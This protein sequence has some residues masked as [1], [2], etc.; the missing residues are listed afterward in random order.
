M[1]KFDLLGYIRKFQILIIAVSILAGIMGYTVLSRMQT[2]T[3]SAII[4]YANSEAVRGKAPDGSQLDTTEIYSANVV[5]EVFSRMGLDYAGFNVDDMRARVEVQALRTNEKAAL[6][7]AL[8]SKGEEVVEKPVEY[9]VSFVAMNQ[10]A[11]NQEEFA[12]QFLDEMLDAYISDYG[13]NHINNASPAINDISKINSHNYDYLEKAELLKNSISSANNALNRKLESADEQFRSTAT[14]YSF[15]DLQ[16]EFAL[17]K[18]V[19]VPEL[20]AY[21]LENHVTQDR[22]VLIAKY[23]NRIHDHRLSNDK[24]QEQIAFVRGIIDAYVNMMRESGNTNITYEY[25]IQDV[26]DNW[27]ELEGTEGKYRADQTVEYDTLLEDY[28]T[29]CTDYEEALVDIAYCQYILDVYHGKG[30]DVDGAVVKTWLNID[31]A[32]AE[33]DAQE[34]NEQ[35]EN[36]QDAAGSTDTSESIDAAGTEEGDSELTESVSKE[37]S[38]EMQQKAQEMIDNLAE[39]A[40]TLHQILEITNSEYNEYIGAKNIKLVAGIAVK[41]RISIKKYVVLLVLVFGI[42]GCMGAIVLGRL[43][44]IFE[45]YVYIDRVLNIP[46][47]AACDR[48]INQYGKRSLPDDFVCVSIRVEGLRDKN[49]VY[50][51]KVTDNMILELVRMIQGIFLRERDVFMG[52]NSAGHFLIFAEHMTAG[53]ARA[54]AAQLNQV[55]AEYNGTEACK[56][57]YSLG[58][59]EAKTENNCQIR[60]LIQAALENS[61]SCKERAAAEEFSSTAYQEA[62]AA[63][64]EK[65]SADKKD[66]GETPIQKRLDELRKALSKE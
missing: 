28:R 66:T 45:Y 61:K 49:Q 17:L 29:E 62:A 63:T 38:H 43:A 11:V 19:W 65:T 64:E 34:G 46:N 8:T 2:Y 42:V 50:G 3:A 39:R 12:R 35:E 23:E 31:D 5:S 1:K 55:T 32:V 60:Q 53:R 13:E 9:K 56:I 7:Q 52:L 57:E 24:R 47:R 37:S 40:D 44:D 27:Y 41:E 54:Y 20:F 22:D 16:K 30:N 58:I 6:D 10:D 4:C 51:R 21:I 26:D 15:V 36:R 48:R 25:I 14:G 18:N 59:A 33:L